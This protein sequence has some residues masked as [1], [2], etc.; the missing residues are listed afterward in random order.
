MI[1]TRFIIHDSPTG[2]VVTTNTDNYKP[3]YQ[4]LVFSFK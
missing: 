2:N 1:Q 4:K 3:L